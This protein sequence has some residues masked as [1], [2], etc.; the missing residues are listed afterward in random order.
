MSDSSPA[1][2]HAARSARTA[3]LVNRL[4]AIVVELEKMHPGRSFPLDG[5]LVGSIGEAAAEAM[6]ALRLLPASTAG[7]D[8]IADDGRAVEIKA[9]YGNSAVGLRTTSHTAAAAL[10]VLRLSRTPAVPHEVIYNGALERVASAAGKV[11]SNGQARLSLPR[12]RQLDATVPD[13]ER[14]GLRLPIS[15]SRES[16][17]NCDPGSVEDVGG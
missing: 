5:H 7:H 16:S 9:T 10:I 15:P 6:F 11:Q 8:A 3:E 13:A 12:L 2:D 4:H 1:V 17:T 14:V